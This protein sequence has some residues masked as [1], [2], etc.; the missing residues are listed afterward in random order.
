M[1]VLNRKLGERI[2]IGGGT[3]GHPEIVITVTE[4]GSGRVKLGIDA[5]RDVPVVREELLPPKRDVRDAT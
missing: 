4:I 5:P 3:L 1:L 2:I